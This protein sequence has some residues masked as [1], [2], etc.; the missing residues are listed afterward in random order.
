MNTYLVFATFV[1]VF[2]AMFASVI[3]GQLILAEVFELVNHCLLQARWKEVA[4]ALGPD[5]NTIIT[6][7]VEQKC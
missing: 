6:Q 4:E 1:V 7:Q 2:T 3:F 5:K